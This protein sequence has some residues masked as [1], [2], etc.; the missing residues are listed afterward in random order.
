MFRHAEIG[1]MVHL[2]AAGRPHQ[3]NPVATDYILRMLGL[4]QV[5]HF[6]KPICPVPC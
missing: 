6:V 4:E 3:K 5:L 1:C 2:Q